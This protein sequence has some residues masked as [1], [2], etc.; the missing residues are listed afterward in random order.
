MEFGFY[1][2]LDYKVPEI[3]YSY[4]ECN[5]NEKIDIFLLGRVLFFL[6]V[7][8]DIPSFTSSNYTNISNDI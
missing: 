2:K 1:P 5:Y 3:L 8:K 6:M 7:G 4:N